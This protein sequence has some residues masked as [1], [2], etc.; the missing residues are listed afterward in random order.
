MAKGGLGS[1][2]YVEE[3]EETQVVRDMRLTTAS[4]NEFSITPKVHA[5]SGIVLAV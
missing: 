4:S 5:I 3:M 2:F 1:I